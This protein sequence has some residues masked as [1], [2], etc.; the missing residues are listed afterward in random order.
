[1]EK[2]V[3]L[4][5]AKLTGTVEISGAKNSAVAILVAAMMVNGK[6][7][8]EN[9]PHV[10][11]IDVLI[12]IINNMGGSATFTADGVVEMDCS[13]LNSCEATYETV[14]K[15][16]ASS[17]LMGALLG[18]FGQARVALPGGCDFG[19]RPIDQ[20]LK[21]FKA[22][23]AEWN[24][25]HGM[26]ELS[27]DKLTGN[28]IYL[29]VIS[30][31]ATINIML[32]S[33]FAEGLTVIDSAA[34]EPHIVDVANFLNCMG[35]DIK[36]AGTDVIKIRGVKELHGGS[37]SVIP[38][39]IEAG[40][41]MIAAAATGGDV[42]VSSIIP[43][44]M[45]F[46][47]AKLE[48]MGVGIEKYDEAIRVFVENEKLKSTNVKT[49]P[50]PGFATDLQ[51]QMLTLLSVASGT[52]VV[53]EN[54]WDNRFKYVGELNRMGANVSVD[55]K[56]ATVE[57]CPYL[58]GAPVSATDLRAGAALVIAGLMAHGVTEVYNLKYIDRGYENFEQKL[59]KLGAQITRRS[60]EGQDS[61]FKE[62]DAR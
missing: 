14:E 17:Y 59:R 62:R 1:M 25:E 44:H 51:P 33:V 49:Q 54:V 39:Q 7:H 9:V 58:T 6:C 43:E 55:G 22:L 50:H 48:E 47:S 32:A 29:D 3:I 53:T 21:G 24:I 2:M 8:I 56:V 60:A 10:S 34:K 15:I 16:R 23:G 30:V 18:R 20:H 31:G 27:A 46:L 40:T 19:I 11:D 13:G 36:G 52:S 61:S 42:L 45:E 37:F 35:A 57:G 5:G 41:F 38:D 4:G 12:D 28:N 26:V